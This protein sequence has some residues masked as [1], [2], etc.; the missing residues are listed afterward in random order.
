MKRIKKHNT[1]AKIG[2]LLWFVIH[3]ALI[4]LGF[5]VPWKLDS[6]LYSILPDSKELK[7]VSAAE[8][9]LSSRTM[10]NVT[11]LVG[12]KEFAV[13]RNAAFALEKAYASDSSFDETRLL[14]NE[15]TL[16]ETREFLF[17]NR[18]AIQ[19]LP[20]REAIEAGNLE[21]LKMGALQ[22]I[23]GSFSLANLNRLEED[24]FLLGESSFDNFM[25][26]SPMVSGRFSLRDGVLAA[27]D[28]GFTY[29][30]WSA[31]L[32][33]NVSHYTCFKC[34]KLGHFISDC[35]L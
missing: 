1:N 18:Y 3:V 9:V 33:E 8:K 34:R 27:T 35:P 14:V 22:K 31:V 10:R 6:D 32:S 12:H 30:M 11:V 29:V 5:S 24:P 15:N 28:S 26:N 16:D 25:F 23:Y 19:N 4:V 21:K 7:N 2:V 13:A 17:K 20:V